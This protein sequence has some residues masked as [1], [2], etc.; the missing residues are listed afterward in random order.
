LIDLDDFKQ[1]NDSYGHDAGDA[2]L[3]A[4]ANLLLSAVRESD[5]VARLG[6]DEFAILLISPTDPT[7]IEMV[8]TRIVASFG[9]G[10]PFGNTVLKS[11]CS[12][13]IAVYPGDGDTQESLYKSSD[14]A[15]YEA[16]RVGGNTI[17]RYHAGL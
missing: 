15:L 12:V 5:C 3:I 16:K 2:V 7:G 6:G 1:V 8:C 11:T 4:S 10:V 17:C 13:G 9:S 14:L